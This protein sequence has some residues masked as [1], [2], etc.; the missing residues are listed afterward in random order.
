MCIYIFL[1]QLNSKNNGT[2]LILKSILRLRNC[3]LSSIA[4]DGKDVHGLKLEKVGPTCPSLN[5][6][7][8][9]I[10][11]NIIMGTGHR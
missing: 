8:A 5:S 1:H 10:A 3:F 7:P 4:T 9:K 2:V 6:M 11:K